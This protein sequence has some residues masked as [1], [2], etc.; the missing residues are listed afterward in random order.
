MATDE[1]LLR[2]FARGDRS[3]L[4]ALAVRYERALL[5]LALAQLGSRDMA[6]DVVQEVWLRVIRYAGTF[7]GR[8]SVKTWLYRVAINQ[9][10]SA[11]A[12]RPID[13]PGSSGLSTDATDDPAR[14]AADSDDC[15]RIRR[16]VE[17]LS[18]P[19]RETV[20]LCY[21]H[22]FT[23]AEAARVMGIPV[24]TVKSRVN[25]ALEQLRQRLGVTRQRSGNDHETGRDEAD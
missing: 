7:N 2:A 8:S 21:T 19:L 20:L 14:R 23:H 18:P 6:V 22:G 1:E 17:T 24:G 5:D 12:S 9:C 15:E 11:I 16:L 10:R 13:S 25:A 3:G 4:E